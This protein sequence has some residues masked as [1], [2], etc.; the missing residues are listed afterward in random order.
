[1]FPVLKTL[2]RPIYI[3][4]NRSFTERFLLCC[5]E[6]NIENVRS[7]HLPDRWAL[8][9]PRTPLPFYKEAHLTPCLYEIRCPQSYA[10]NCLE[11]NYQEFLNSF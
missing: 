10:Q 8:V 3:W 2:D 1:M 6:R 9:S 11:S 5:F 4:N 7:F